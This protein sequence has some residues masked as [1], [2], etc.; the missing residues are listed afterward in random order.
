MLDY[1]YLK[2]FK[3]HYELIAIDLSKQK[4]LDSDPRSEFYGMLN[5]DSQVL[6]DIEKS[7]ETIL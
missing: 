3:D 4:E 5:I 2:Y 6:K 7:K 1:K